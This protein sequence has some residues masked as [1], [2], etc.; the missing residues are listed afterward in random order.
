MIFELPITNEPSQEFICELAGIDYIFRLTLNVRADLW[1]LDVSS[2]D[3]Y[4]IVQ[5]LP[6][7]LGSDLLATERFTVGMLFI[8]DYNNKGDDP[9]GDNI[10]DYG[11]IWWDGTDDE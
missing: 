11:L 4:P 1:M 7:V 2:V 6:L 5:G 10:S 3:D 9:N 8:A